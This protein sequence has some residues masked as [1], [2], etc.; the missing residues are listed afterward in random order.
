MI[1]K[2]KSEKMVAQLILLDSN[3]GLDNGMIIGILLG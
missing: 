3:H 1:D 2:R